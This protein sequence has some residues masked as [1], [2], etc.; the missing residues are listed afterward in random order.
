MSS[1]KDEGRHVL[2]SY[3]WVFDT[4][5]VLFL[6]I[7]TSADVKCVSVMK[8]FLNVRDVYDPTS[9]VLATAHSWI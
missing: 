2:S 5:R 9:H 1:E 7:S 3:I 6:S 8:S 4:H